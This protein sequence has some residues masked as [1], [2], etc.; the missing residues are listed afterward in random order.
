MG[1]MCWEESVSVD[2]ALLVNFAVPDWKPKFCGSLLAV[3]FAKG[4]F[5]SL[6]INELFLRG[7]QQEVA[8]LCGWSCHCLLPVFRT[9]ELGKQLSR[10][11]VR[12]RSITDL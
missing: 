10:V 4:M 7:L 2:G 11:K 5:S 12:Y 8:L 3:L 9:L 6:E 1:M